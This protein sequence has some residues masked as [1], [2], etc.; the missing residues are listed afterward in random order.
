M[1]QLLKAFVDDLNVHNAF[2]F[3]QLK[4]LHLVLTRLKEVKLK[5]NLKCVF[6]VKRIHILRHVVSWKGTMCDPLKIR[7]MVEYHVSTWVIDVH[8][9]VGLINYYQNYSKVQIL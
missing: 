1:Q 4:H 7:E 5:L 9:F 2:W 3:E 8:A 6:I